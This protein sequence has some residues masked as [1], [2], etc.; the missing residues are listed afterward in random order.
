M[1]ITGISTR[2]LQR[3]IRKISEKF[4]VGQSV[5]VLDLV[6]GNVYS[7]TKVSLGCKPCNTCNHKD[8]NESVDVQLLQ[9]SINVNYIFYD[10][11][12]EK[13][14]INI[15]GGWL[16]NPTLTTKDD[17][18]I[19][20]YTIV[21]GRVV[22]KTPI[23]LETVN[24]VTTTDLNSATTAIALFCSYN[25]ATWTSWSQVPASP[26]SSNAFVAIVSNSDFGVSTVLQYSF[27][28][29]NQ[30][31]TNKIIVNN[32]VTKTELV[33]PENLDS[34]I[35]FNQL[36]KLPP[37]GAPGQDVG[38]PCTG[39]T[40]TVI[41]YCKVTSKPISGN[42]NW[43]RVQP[44]VFR[45]NDTYYTRLNVLNSG[46]YDITIVLQNISLSYASLFDVQYYS[47]GQ[48]ISFKST[49]SPGNNGYDI[50]AKATGVQL[51]ANQYWTL[52]MTLDCING[53]PVDTYNTT[54]SISVQRIGDLPS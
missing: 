38:S 9:L 20:I 3:T 32:E 43:E 10:R 53:R 50:T 13:L 15:S 1:I 6:S 54:G 46:L 7:V 37:L 16:I 44:G 21:C 48:R 31:N 41:N 26:S 30:P 2:C 33:I 11:Y 28:P 8:D 45:P 34:V 5:N 23:V 24:R 51:V 27:Y 18:N 39:P 4:R 12:Q 49:T 29:T 40:L 52:L 19:N 17:D 25:Q 42:I 47:S 36:N 35:S 14:Y 22:S